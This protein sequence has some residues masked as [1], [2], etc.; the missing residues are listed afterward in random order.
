MLE[1]PEDDDNPWVQFSKILD[2]EAYKNPIFT[3]IFATNK[4]TSMLQHY[5]YPMFDCGVTGHSG[6]FL[7]HLRFS[8]VMRTAWSEV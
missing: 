6:K 8:P 1:N 2:S 7:G 5:G 4:T 3:V